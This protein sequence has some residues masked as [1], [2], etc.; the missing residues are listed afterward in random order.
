MEGGDYMELSFEY[1]VECLQNGVTYIPYT[2]KILVAV[3]IIANIIAFVFATVQFY[4]IPIL[5]QLTS[6]FVTIW[7][8][9]PST[10]ALVVGY[11]LVMTNFTSWAEALH[12]PWGIKDVDF[13]YVAIIILIATYACPIS[14]NFRSAYKAIGK[15]QFEAGYSIG[16]TEIQTLRRIIIPQLIPIMIPSE[17]S[18]MIIILKNISLISSIGLVEIMGGCLLVCARTYSY[19][20]GYVA[21]AV[22]YWCIA[23]IIEQVGK[24]IEKN[25]SKHRRKS[26]C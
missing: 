13:L 25:A 24:R 11:L 20:E 19:F 17:V 21:A 6:L 23:I 16:L 22:I 7:L 9:I 10:L 1:F 15:T 14:E 2:L 3:F 5:S 8:G 12:L 4:R 18:W 26:V